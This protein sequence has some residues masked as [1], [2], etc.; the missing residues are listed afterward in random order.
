ASSFTD[1]WRRI[2]IYWKD[3]MMKLVYYPTYFQLRRR[4]TNFGM[5]A[6]TIIVYFGT[7]ILHSYQWFWLRAGFPFEL[8]DVLFWSILG[9]LVVFGSLHEMRGPSRRSLRRNSTW[10]ASLAL[11]TVGTFAVISVLWSIWSS[12]SLQTWLTMWGAAGNITF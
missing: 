4:G 5:V 12:D 10:S 1:F 9:A 3:F 7:W 11:R 6:S 8:Q 2:N